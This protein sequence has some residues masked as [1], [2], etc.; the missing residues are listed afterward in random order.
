MWLARR[1]QWRGGAPTGADGFR[2]RSSP[3]LPDPRGRPSGPASRRSIPFGGKT[4][5]PRGIRTRLGARRPAAQAAPPREGVDPLQLLGRLVGDAHLLV[6]QADDLALA[7][8]GVGDLVPPRHL[9]LDS[10]LAPGA[11]ADGEG[12]DAAVLLGDGRAQADHLDE[13][14]DG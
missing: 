5:P 4:T 6:E 3:F 9:L 11:Q 10:T 14:V 13:V 1:A 8:V 2:D 12:G 7:L